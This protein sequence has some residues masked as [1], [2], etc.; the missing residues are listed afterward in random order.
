MG[1]IIGRLLVLV[2]AAFVLTSAGVMLTGQIAPNVD[3][4]TSRPT[5]IL[6]VL[7]CMAA[8][9]AAMAF[10]LKVLARFGYHF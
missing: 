8:I 2:I 7:G 3:P 5:Y 10:S 6:V 1:L 9:V 4:K